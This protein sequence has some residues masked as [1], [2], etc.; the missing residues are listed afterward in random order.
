MNLRRETCIHE[1][2]HAV[3]ALC[4]K[5][6]VRNI[7]VGANGRG[8]CTILELR[9]PENDRE[10]VLRAC[11]TSFAGVVASNR[12]GSREGCGTDFKNIERALDRIEDP[13]ERAAISREARRTAE[14][15]VDLNWEA[16]RLLAD[17]LDKAGKLG[18]VDVLDF[19]RGLPLRSRRL[20]LARRAK[21]AA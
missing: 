10:A 16:L 19:L 6:F 9:Q 14:R 8:M 15:L 20:G 18:L 3:G 2:G 4:Q 12:I 21:A 1:S 7:E 11:I 17:R 5:M 13:W